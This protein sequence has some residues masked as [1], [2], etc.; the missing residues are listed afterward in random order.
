MRFLALL[1]DELK[2]CTNSQPNIAEGMNAYLHS[3]RELLFKGRVAIFLS[4]HHVYR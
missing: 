2:K 3:V 4:Y 1:I